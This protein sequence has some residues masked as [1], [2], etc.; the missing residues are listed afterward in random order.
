VVSEGGRVF[1]KASQDAYVDGNGRIV[2]TGTKGGS[3]E[4]LGNRVAVMDKAE[5]DASGHR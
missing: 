3:V 5:I 4:V 2:T 1:L